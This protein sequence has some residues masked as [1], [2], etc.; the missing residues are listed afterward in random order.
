MDFLPSVFPH[1][2]SIN[3]RVK[4]MASFRHT[5]AVLS[6]LLLRLAL[7]IQSP[8]FIFS[9]VV[10]LCSYGL[11]AEYKFNEHR[12]LLLQ[13]EYCQFP[14]SPKVHVLKSLVPGWQNWEMAKLLRDR[15]S[16]D[17]LRSLWGRDLRRVYWPSQNLSPA[18]HRLG[19]LG[20]FANFSGPSG[21]VP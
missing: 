14:S 5:Q 20:W 9:S 3:H 11:C 2:A 7:S 13:L 16:W 6:S 18:S 8:G 4:H 1:S 17:S 21:L 12:R 10:L 15:E 19:A